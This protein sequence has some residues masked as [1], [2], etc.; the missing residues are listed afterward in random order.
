MMNPGDHSDGGI[1][2]E[3]FSDSNEPIGN[4]NHNSE[5]FEFVRKHPWILC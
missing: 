5:F 1:L 2:S 4:D 3:A